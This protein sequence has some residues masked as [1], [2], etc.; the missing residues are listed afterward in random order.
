MPV[1]NIDVLSRY[2]ADSENATLDKLGGEAW[3]RR[4]ARM[5]ERIREIAGDLLATAAKRALRPAPVFEADAGSYAAFV[6]RFP[7]QETDDQDRAI[8]DVLAD[9][10]SGRPMDRLV[11]GDVGFGKTEVALR[12]AFVAAMAGVQ[13]AVV[14]PTTLL[15]R[16]H[17]TNFVERF[18]GF[19]VNIGRLAGLV[20]SGEAQK[21][22][23]I[24]I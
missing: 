21:L 1:E 9:M 19:P 5:K 13:V 20:P 23:L 17:Y 7:Y 11:C 2:G 12:A 16:Q 8:G 4:K 24:H 18:K 14:V 15:A 3:Q 6:D 10:A 22:S